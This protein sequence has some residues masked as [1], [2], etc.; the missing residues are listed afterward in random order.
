MKPAADGQTELC[1]GV[2]AVPEKGKA[3]AALLRLLAKQ[4][5]LPARELT[6]ISGAT[7]R[8]KQVLVKG[9]PAELQ[10]LVAARL[11]AGST[12]KK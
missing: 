11:P 9:E 8:H 5:R 7:D 12:K 10:T 4:L 6:L 1:V 3:N 2:T